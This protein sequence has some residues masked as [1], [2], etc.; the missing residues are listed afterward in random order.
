M[1]QRQQQ[2]AYESI[3]MTESCNKIKQTNVPETGKVK[4]NSNDVDYDNII[5]FV[6]VMISLS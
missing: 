4:N 3:S 2:I 6:I 5:S 1:E